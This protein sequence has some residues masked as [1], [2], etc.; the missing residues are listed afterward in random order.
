M[1]L[2]RHL[3]EMYKNFLDFLQIDVVSEPSFCLFQFALIKNDI[4]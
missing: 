1:G 3:W 2:A 4:K